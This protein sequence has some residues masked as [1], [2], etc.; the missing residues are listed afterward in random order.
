M[1]YRRKTYKILPEMLEPFNQFFHTYLY[2]NQRQHGAKLIGRWT[3]DT[4]T[5]IVAIWAY[6][7]KEHYESIETSIRASDLHKQAQKKTA[8]ARS[9][10]FGKYAG[11]SYLNSSLLVSS[12]K[13]DC[14]GCWIN[15]K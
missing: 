12:S 13:T 7:S 11:I 2:P 14:L 4:H 1:I 5:E 15:Y 9:A 3:N 10:V 6:I 8:G